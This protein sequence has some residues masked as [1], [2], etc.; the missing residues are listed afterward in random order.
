MIV[1]LDRLTITPVEA[2]LPEACPDCGQ[3]FAE[4]SGL[5]E[6]GYVASSQP[7]QIVT[8]GGV[9]AV[10]DYES[11]DVIAELALTV[12]YRC[13]GC[14]A[15]MVSTDESYEAKEAATG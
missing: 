5:V 13:G 8:E 2:A 15:V 1:T 4:P 14:N 7:C 3:D 11:G 6:F 12:G 10:S 9:Q